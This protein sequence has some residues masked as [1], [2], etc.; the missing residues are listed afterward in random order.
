[1]DVGSSYLPSD[2]LAAF[3]LAQLEQREKVQSHRRRVWE[4]YKAHLQDWARAYAVQLPYIPSYCEQ[5]YHMFPLLLPTLELRQ[6]L[7]AHLR[8]HGINSVFHYLPLHLSDMG[9]RFGGQPGDCPVTER[10]SDQ[11]VRLPFHNALTDEDLWK[12]V[13]A[14]QEYQF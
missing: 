11:L 2:I 10:V 9:R 13:E 1:V 3:L 12:V 6:G 4:F 14:V 8:W 7:I 5:S